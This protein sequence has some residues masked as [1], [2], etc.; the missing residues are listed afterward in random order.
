MTV[1]KCNGVTKTYGAHQVLSNINFSIEEGVLTGIIGRNG[2][3]KTTLMKMIVGF[4]RESSGSIQVFGEQPFNNL[5]VSAN[6][7]FIDDAMH[8]PDSMTLQDILTE[9]QR[10][11]PNW[12]GELAS[13]LISYFVFHLGGKHR[14]LSKGK[15]S[16]FNAII[17]LAAHCALTIFDEPT[18]GMDAAVRKDF[19][20]ALL[21]DY[22]AHPRTILVSSH[23]IEE[24]ED[25]LEDI[26]LVHEGKV[27]FHGPI[28][29]LQEMFV[30]LQGTAELL[31]IHTQDKN[32]ISQHTLGPYSEWLV[33]N[34]FT[35]DQIKH[36][37]AS[38]ISLSPVSANDAYIA[39]T[40]KAQGGIDHVFN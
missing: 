40:T 21:K 28:T 18:T 13:R 27:Q 12:D 8:F 19:Y 5:K 37:Q 32:I 14:L 7:I 38:G 39:L 2:V 1:I 10:F 24:I 3:G 33:E 16:T 23:H 25:L 11:Y 31:A 34:T 17:G 35:D 36:L 6:T 26:L 4:L 30:T 20:R 9:C 29:D 15:K 22:S